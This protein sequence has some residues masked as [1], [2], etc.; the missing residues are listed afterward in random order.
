MHFLFSEIVFS[1][2]ICTEFYSF[3]SQV[4]IN[5]LFQN[6]ETNNYLS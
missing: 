2:L 6:S 4:N 5:S 3:I 1:D